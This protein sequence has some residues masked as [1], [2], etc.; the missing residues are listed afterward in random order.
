M[1]SF[2]LISWLIYG[3]VVWSLCRIGQGLCFT[4]YLVPDFLFGTLTTI[5][6]VCWIKSVTTHHIGSSSNGL[7]FGS[8][9]L[10]WNTI[11]AFLDSPLDTPLTATLNIMVGYI[12][13]I[14]MVMPICYWGLNF[15]IYSSL[16]N[17]ALGNEYV[18]MGIVNKKFELAMAL[19]SLLAIFT[20]HINLSMFFAVSFGIGFSAIASILYLVAIFNERTRLMKKYKDIPNSWFHAMLLISFVLALVL[21]IFM[22]DE[23]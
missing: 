23:I 3:V 9:D 6:W 18:V 11:V 7:G 12:L 5:S 15:P 1:C 20:G 21:V 2:C 13:L 19:A 17:T 16:L 4:W 14:Y 22:K 8:F 10:Y